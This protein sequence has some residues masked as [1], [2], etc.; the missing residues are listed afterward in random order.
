MAKCEIKM[1]GNLTSFSQHLFLGRGKGEKEA[2]RKKQIA[3]FVHKG[4]LWVFV[5]WPMLGNA[6]GQM[7]GGQAQ[8]P[9]APASPSLLAIAGNA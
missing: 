2:K 4:I 8:R 9:E 5:V 1:Q 7:P 6:H 3:G